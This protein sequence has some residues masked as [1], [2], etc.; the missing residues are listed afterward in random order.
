[1]NTR[2]QKGSSIIHMLCAPL[3]LSPVLESVIDRS[4]CPLGENRA[5]GSCQFPRVFVSHVAFPSLFFD[6]LSHHVQVAPL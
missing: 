1:M 2:E 4:V 5:S 3:N 6:E